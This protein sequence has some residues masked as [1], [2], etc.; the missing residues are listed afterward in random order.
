MTCFQPIPLE[1]LVLNSYADGPVPRSRH[2]RNGRTGSSASSTSA[3][4]DG[5]SR[6]LYPFTINHKARAGGSYVLYA[7]SIHGRAEWKQKLEEVMGLRKVVQESN[8]V[9]EMETLSVNTFSVQPVSPGSSLST[10]SEG[11]LITGKVTCSIP[12]SKQIPHVSCGIF[13]IYTIRYT[14]RTAVGCHWM[15]RGCLDRVPA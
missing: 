15:C 6:L 4:E 1:L 11:G 3:S 13:L 2:G 14:R 12:F 8:K 7:D 10:W 5:E 9:F